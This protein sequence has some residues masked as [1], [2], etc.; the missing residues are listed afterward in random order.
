M[1]LSYPTLWVDVLNTNMVKIKYA[2]PKILAG[3]LVG[4]RGPQFGN[5]CPRQRAVKHVYVCVCAALLT[6]VGNVAARNCHTCGGRHSTWLPVLQPSS[7][8]T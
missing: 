3:H 7:L 5:H 8:Q 4:S 2:Q 6:G 1:R